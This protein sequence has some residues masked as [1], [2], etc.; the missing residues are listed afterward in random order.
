MQ[1]IEEEGEEEEEEDEDGRRRVGLKRF[2]V[3][4]LFVWTFNC[5]LTYTSMI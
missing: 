1:F 4:R 3:S 5:W 2:K